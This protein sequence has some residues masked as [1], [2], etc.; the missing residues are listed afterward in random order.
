MDA[1]AYAA[2]SI[3]DQVQLTNLAVKLRSDYSGRTMY[4]RTCL[5]VVGDYGTCKQFLQELRQEAL[6]TAADDG[7]DPKA[8][9]ALFEQHCW[10]SMGL[11]EI[12]Y[13]PGLHVSYEE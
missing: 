13:W 6:A 4:G 1:Q 12:L 2:L 11:Q 8:L 5:G 3:S 10:D 7:Q 9:I